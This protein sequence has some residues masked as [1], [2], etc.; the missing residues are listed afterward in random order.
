MKKLTISY[1]RIDEMSGGGV[2]VGTLNTTG[3][4]F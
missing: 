4:M 3:K 1:V 2:G